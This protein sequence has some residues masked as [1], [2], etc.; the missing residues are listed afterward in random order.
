M[1]TMQQF[2]DGAKNFVQTSI[3]PH[4]P[5]DRQ[6]AAGVAIG[7]VTNKADTMLR[8]LKDSQMVQMLGL[9]DENGMVDD[10]A[11]FAAMRDQMQRQGGL[12]FDIPWIGRMTFNALDVD[13]L[14][15]SIRGR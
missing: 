12:Q 7:L 10:D 4:L 3:I 5:N 11:L 6:F 13:A 14:Q 15:R 9:V 1:V 8:R 2:V